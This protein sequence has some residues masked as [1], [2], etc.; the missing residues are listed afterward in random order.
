MQPMLMMHGK[1]HGYNM[2]VM[3]YVGLKIRYPLI[4]MAKCMSFPCHMMPMCKLR[5]TIMFHILFN[6]FKNLISGYYFHLFI[7]GNSMFE[8]L[9]LVYIN[10]WLY[11]NLDLW[12]IFNNQEL[13]W[14]NHVR[15]ENDLHGIKSLKPHTY[16]C[17]QRK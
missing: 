7:Y 14:T 9:Y 11:E 2:I 8:K 3:K 1:T 5:F 16:L 12:N 10:S 15:N 17:H 4:S 6:I 13:L